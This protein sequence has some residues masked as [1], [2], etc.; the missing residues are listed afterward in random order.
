MKDFLKTYSKNIS[1]M[2]L[3]LASLLLVV[4]M[5]PKRASFKYDF[6][7]GKPWKHDNLLA[8]FDFAILKSNDVLSQEK[9]VI[10]QN[11][12]PFYQL[13]NK[14]LPQKLDHFKGK[15]AQE[16]RIDAPERDS[17]FLKKFRL[18][19]LAL[20]E[21][22]NM[23]IVDMYPDHELRREQLVIQL[24]H[25]E[26]VEERALSAFYTLA[27]ASR[28]MEELVSL[29]NSLE[30]DSLNM[31]GLLEAELAY[32]VIYDKEKTEIQILQLTDNLSLT[33][34]KVEKDEG[35][36][37]RGEIVD[38]VKF[39]KIN[40]LKEVYNKT[41]GETG[42]VWIGFG[43]GIIVLIC[44]IAMLLFMSL[45]IQDLF[46]Q[47]SKVSFLIICLLLAVLLT[48]AINELEVFSIYL[49]P[50]CI[51]PIV[52]KAFYDYRVALFVHLVILMVLGLLVSKPFEF[53]TMQ[54][55]AA[56]AVLFKLGQIKKRSQFFVSAA[57][58]FVSYV[59]VY[60]AFTI[61]QDG[62]V[63]QIEY[64]DFAWLAGSA[65]L[66]LFAQPFIYMVE[67]LFGFV[68]E[69]TLME[70]AD[71]NNFL[72]RELASKAP[73][74]FQ[75][76]LQVANLAESCIQ[77]IGGDALL[78]RA[79]ALYHDIGKM[80]Q[81]KFFIE[82]QHNGLN[83]HNELSPEDSADIIIQHVRDGV[84]LARKHG[85]PDMIIDFIKTH[86]GTTRTEY[87]YRKAKEKDPEIS[88][89]IFKYP[90]PAPITREMSVLMMCDSVEAASRSLKEY[91]K[92]T[93]SNLV[94]GIIDHQMK[95]NQFNNADITFR[96]IS[97]L[98][99]FLKRKLLDI[100]HVRVEYPK[101]Q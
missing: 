78:I 57:I 93:I 59:V 35:V 16:M 4:Y 38:Q 75:H 90:G 45:F 71:T 61:I 13:N 68:S 49:V 97:V 99:K 73:G 77:Q 70:M 92:E 19:V 11:F 85:L 76:T 48:K 17:E 25:G 1:T 81:P 29:R 65:M 26:K 52:L 23:G 30:N 80:K 2:L 37:L 50:L 36:I 6:Q 8:P 95:L 22:Y 47:F 58:V 83:P 82:N 55:I 101:E 88:E 43:Q 32:N 63:S 34:G 87:F 51:I 14:I 5:L 94:D 44:L 86:H 84:A 67:K 18:G 69:T 100:Y 89:D 41:I 53:L 42:N 15:L 79:G 72:L 54:G 9:E 3:V 33:T 10:Q 39:Q 74:T 60:F 98:K 46:T 21:V 28:K 66:T 64:I 24:I 31:F 96:D 91:S 12:A 62:G 56:M 20:T 7:I 27:T 40:S